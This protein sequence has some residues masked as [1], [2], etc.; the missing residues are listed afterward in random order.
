MKMM[1][2]IAFLL[3][4]VSIFGCARV[5]KT[6]EDST[7]CEFIDNQ[8]EQDACFFDVAKQANDTAVCA[9]INDTLMKEKCNKETKK[10]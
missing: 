4:A 7:P 9:D 3:L 5:A 8:T 10:P 2:T 6:A 1:A